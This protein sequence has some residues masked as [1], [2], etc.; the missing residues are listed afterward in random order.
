MPTLRS[1]SPSSLCPLSFAMS[2][3]FQHSCHVFSCAQ[4]DTPVPFQT[5]FITAYDIKDIKRP[6]GSRGVST[7]EASPASVE[8]DDG[9]G[10]GGGGG[11]GGDGGV[12][13][14]GSCGAGRSRSF[15]SITGVHVVD[16]QPEGP[17]LYLSN[18]YFFRSH[19]FPNTWHRRIGCCILQGQTGCALSFFFFFFRLQGKM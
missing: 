6:E 15:K 8:G 17:S 3:P 13:A 10:G 16:P 18:A 19:P 4:N 7:F 2:C 9:G 11:V 12:D 5:G 1:P 14:G